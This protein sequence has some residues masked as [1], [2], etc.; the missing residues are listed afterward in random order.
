MK[1]VVKEWEGW[2]K[3]ADDAV[4]Q[5][6]LNVVDLARQLNT[7]MERYIEKGMGWCNTTG[8]NLDSIGPV[9]V[10]QYDHIAVGGSVFHALASLDPK[11]AEAAILDALGLTDD[12][13]VWCRSIAGNGF[14]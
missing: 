1:I 8:F 2:G 5:V 10:I 11:E 13:A 6:A 9:R 3:R 14:E 12:D 4:L 7:P